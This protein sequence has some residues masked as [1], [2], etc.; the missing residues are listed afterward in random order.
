MWTCK[1]PPE[2]LEPP[3][4]TWGC[5]WCLKWRALLWDCGVYGVCLYIQV[6][7]VKTELN[8]QTPCSCPRIACWYG[9]AYTY[10]QIQTRTNKHA[11]THTNKHA[12][13]HMHT[14]ELGPEHNL[15]GHRVCV[16]TTQL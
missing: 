15:A 13:T 7:S 11:C 1:W 8:P 3:I 2:L 14:L 16:T 4:A 5:D 6:D 10:T 9:E 12:C